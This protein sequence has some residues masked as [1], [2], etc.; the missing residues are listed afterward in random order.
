MTKITLSDIITAIRLHDDKAVYRWVGCKSPDSLPEA[1]KCKGCYLHRIETKT[2]AG[3]NVIPANPDSNVF[4]QRNF[5]SVQLK[6][7]E[8]KE[9]Y[10]VIGDYISDT[11]ELVR[12]LAQQGFFR[13]EKKE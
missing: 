10:C 13:Q 2:Y 4:S 5:S 8:Q 12:R 3:E 1:K 9:P 6:D 11:R 7:F